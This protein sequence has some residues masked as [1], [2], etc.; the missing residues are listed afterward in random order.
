MLKI[1]NIILEPILQVQLRASKYSMR[2]SFIDS[3][4]E[5]KMKHDF[6]F[7]VGRRAALG[8]LFLTLYRLAFGVHLTINFNFF[9]FQIT[10]SLLLVGYWI[11]PCHGSM[12]QMRQ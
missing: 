3:L 9:I 8:R 2:S 4:K 12:R 1:I 5:M 11:I 6:A 7:H 10:R